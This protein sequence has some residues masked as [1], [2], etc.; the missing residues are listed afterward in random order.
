[1]RKC[2]YCGLENAEPLLSC[3]RC[4]AELLPPICPPAL[5]Q[6]PATLN[7]PVP[8]P[9]LTAGWATLILLAFLGVQLVSGVLIGVFIG[10]GSGPGPDRFADPKF[11]ARVS[12]KAAVPAILASVVGGGAAVA[13]LAGLLLGTQVSDAGPEGAAWRVGPGRRLAE[14]LGIGLLAGFLYLVFAGLLAPSGA[15]EHLG[16][17]ARMAQTP[18]VPQV[19]WLLLALALAPVIEELLFRGILYGGYRHSFG[20]AWAAVVT[21]TIFVLL[22][23]SE[24]IHFLPALLG[25]TLLAVLALWFRLRSAAIGPAVAVHFGYNS[26]IALA[27][28]LGTTFGQHGPKS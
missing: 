20:P 3:S 26:M 14:G 21:T 22:H 7:G 16:P 8:R 18:G 28:I 25:I 15:P 5:L 2:D 10:L 13:L 9:Q 6:P 1:M 24:A 4:G 12:E 19:S 17:I 27:A 23:L 11:V